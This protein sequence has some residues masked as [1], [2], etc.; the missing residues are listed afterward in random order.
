MFFP[1]LFLYFLLGLL[2]SRKALDFF[3][4]FLVLTQYIFE[5]KFGILSC[6]LGLY[7]QH[8]RRFRF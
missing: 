6:I 4:V 8:S 5:D 2:F 1:L 7:S 3:I